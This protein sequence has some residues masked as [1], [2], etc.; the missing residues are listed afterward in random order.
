MRLTAL[1][2][3]LAVLSLAACSPA[4][5]NGAQS[6][7]FATAQVPMASGYPLS[8]QPKM[9]AMAHWDSPAWRP[10]SPATAPRPHGALPSKGTCASTSPRLRPPRSA[11]PTARP[12]LTRLVDYGVPVSFTPD[13][14]AVLEVGVETVTHH[15]TLART[16]SGR[17]LIADPDFVQAKDG[18]YPQ[19]PMVSEESGLFG[20]ETPQTEIQVTSALVHN[21]GYLYRDS[22]IFYV[23]GRDMAHYK[24]GA[25]TGDVELKRYSLVNK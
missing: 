1:F 10:R 17:L 3:L 15:R 7:S 23:D 11:N 12:A 14:A 13:G 6:D 8:S 22:S 18:R 16:R 21:G 25:P 2:A 4:G 9:Q 24:L 19:V 5:I 20:P